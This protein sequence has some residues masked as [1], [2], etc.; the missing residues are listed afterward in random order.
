M[1]F[2]NLMKWQNYMHYVLLAIG[3]TAVFHFMGIH[4][5]HT[6]NFLPNLNFLHM[7]V[8]LFVLDTL[9]HWLFAVLPE[10]FKWED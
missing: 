8:A 4:V 9:I 10:P 7:V 2:T 6:E 3:M 5:F 1:K